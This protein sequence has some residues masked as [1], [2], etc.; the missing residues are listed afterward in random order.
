MKHCTLREWFFWY[1]Y[2]DLN[3]QYLI[4]L[5]ERIIVLCIIE[6]KYLKSDY[7]NNVITS[8]VD[9]WLDVTLKYVLI[10]YFQNKNNTVV[11]SLFQIVI[12]YRYF[13]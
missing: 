3:G 8:L 9:I 7:L 6:L 13:K 1:V 12:F 2:L 4:A 10:S 5:H 11:I